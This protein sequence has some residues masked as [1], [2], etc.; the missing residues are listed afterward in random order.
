MRLSIYIVLQTV[1]SLV[2]VVENQRLYKKSEQ[3][4]NFS[5]YFNLF[6]G[7]LF[8]FSYYR[9]YLKALRERASPDFIVLR[10]LQKLIV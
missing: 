9:T 6:S 3:S 8:Q 10:F 4:L 1:N 7:W 5:S 2:F